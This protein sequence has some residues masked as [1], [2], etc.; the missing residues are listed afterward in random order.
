LEIQHQYCVKVL[1]KRI[2]GFLSTIGAADTSINN[3]LVVN[4]DYTTATGSINLTK[5]AIPCKPENISDIVDPKQYALILEE[6]ADLTSFPKGFSLVSN[7][8]TY[9][10]DDFNMTEYVTA[11][12]TGYTPPA[13]G[14]FP[15]YG[16]NDDPRAVSVSGQLGSAASE[17]AANPTRPLDSKTM[18]GG[19]FA[20]DRITVNL[21]PI[22]HPAELPPISMMNWL[23]VLEEKRKASMVGY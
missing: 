21:R 20:A 15:R 23:V 8:R 6:C 19:A 4:V 11:P 9:I 12:P 14:Y 1:P 3:S 13:D 16:V 10:G 7:L 2:A 22:T 5:P 18:S 17:D